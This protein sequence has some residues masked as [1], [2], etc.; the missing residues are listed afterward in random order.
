MYN[1]R[2]SLQKHQK[3]V[4]LAVAVIALAVY[5]VP[6]G[7]FETADAAKPSSPCKTLPNGDPNPGVA[8]RST[9]GN[10]NCGPK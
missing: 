4:F 10:T 6:M 7:L 2:N 9:T 5:A 1:I 8:K 3:L